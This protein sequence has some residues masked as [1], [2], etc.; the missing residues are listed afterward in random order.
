MPAE[1]INE[2]KKR[3]LALYL[4]QD[5]P[6]TRVSAIVSELLHNGWGKSESYHVEFRSGLAL[7]LTIRIVIRTSVRYVPSTK[8]T[9]V[10]RSWDENQLSS[11]LSDASFVEAHVAILN[12][13][14]SFISRRKE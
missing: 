9:Y 4:V 1:S 6:R 13:S 8:S 7:K 11:M 5:T 3:Y 2:D 12:Q 10:M 14:S